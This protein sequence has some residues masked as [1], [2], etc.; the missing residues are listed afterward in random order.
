MSMPT[1]TPS[2]TVGPFFHLG[3]LTGTENVLVDEQT[4]GQRIR[5][6]GTVLDGQG[7]P[8]A[9]ALVEIWQADAQGY[10]DH[11]ADLHSSLADRHFHGFG[12]AGTVKSGRFE[13]TTVK[14]G[15]TP[16]RNGE[17]QAPYV[18]VRV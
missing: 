1:Q 10:F 11:P 17:Q 3:L 18:D 12:R 13:F 2:Q 9:D 7:A 14:P 8:V 6:I 4:V 16:G 5:I 15:P